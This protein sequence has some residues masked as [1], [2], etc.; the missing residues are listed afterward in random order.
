[1]PRSILIV[2]DTP[3]IRRAIRHFFEDS[4]WQVCGEAENGAIAVEMVKQLG[5]DAVILDFQMPIMNGLDAAREISKLAPKTT[6]FMLTMHKSE[7]LQQQARAVGIDAV[8]S[9][10]DGLGSQLLASLKKVG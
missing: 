7:A 4:E 8:F 10:S 5:P 3:A 6:M 2:D 9:K 1:M